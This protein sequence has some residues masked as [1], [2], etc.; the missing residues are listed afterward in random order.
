[1][2]IVPAGTVVAVELTFLGTSSGAPT[3]RRNVSALAV[4]HGSTWD[5]VDC[6]EATQHRIMATPLSVARLRRIF[7]THLHGDHVFGLWGL[8]GSRSMNNATTPLRLVGPRGLREMTETVLSLSDSHLT[9]DLDVV[10]LPDDGG[11][12]ADDTL[13]PAVDALPLDHRVTSFA[14]RFTEADRPG[15]VDADA[16][17]AL[18]LDGPDIGRVVRGENVHGADGHPI[19]RAAVVGPERPG[20]V[21]VVAGDNRDPGHLCARI[22]GADLLVHESTY[23]EDALE[24]MDGDYGHS[25]AARVAT[26]AASIRLPHLVL[27]HFSPRYRLEPG[28]AP[29]IADVEA[30][31]RLHFSGGLHLARD[32][33]RYELTADGDFV[34]GTPIEL[35]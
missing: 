28:P 17:A 10:E 7:I 21:Y 11:P 14:Y 13:G 15:A 5:L 16:A 3:R 35:S 32:G 22:A 33:A 4:S 20:R 25:T 29:S 19:D 6:G 9:F 24:S 1:M 8:L 30:E 23:T 26:A 18:G 34:E 2:S 12:A 31:A 27:T